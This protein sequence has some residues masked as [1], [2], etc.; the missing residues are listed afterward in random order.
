M[1]VVFIEEKGYDDRGV[2]EKL[3]SESDQERGGT[4][5]SITIT[6]FHVEGAVQNSDKVWSS[7]V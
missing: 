1:T 7:T 5:C 2:S 3:F 6:K 4:P